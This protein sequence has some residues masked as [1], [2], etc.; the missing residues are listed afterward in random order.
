MP[1]AP[2]NVSRLTLQEGTEANMSSTQKAYLAAIFQTSI[3]GFSFLFIKIA[4]SFT[5][6]LDLLA[7][8]FSAA[9]LIAV[10]VMLIGKIKLNIGKRDLLLILP[11]A[12][13]YPILFFL[14]QTLGLVHIASSEAGIISAVSPVFTLLLASLFL[15]E[16]ANTPQKLFILL[17]V[18]GVIFIFIMQGARI[19]NY[20]FWGV[21]LLL[22]STLSVALYSILA[23]RL[24]IQYP[25]F[26]L[27]FIMTAFG[28]VI[29]SSLALVTHLMAGTLR[30]LFPP[31]PNLTLVLSV[32][33]LGGFSSFLSSFLSNYALSKLE[34][35]RMSIFGNLATV[36]TIVA[37]VI[38]LQE[39]F[40]WYHLLGTL[41]ILT[42]VLG[43]NFWQQK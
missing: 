1:N 33:Y 31:T 23:R 34:A 18:S 35:F 32:L 22:L 41:C 13:F 36:I 43:T 21:L 15:N 6:P 39:S 25:I 30:E 37:G 11:L 27:T 42:G 29:F 20:N 40:H 10:L 16:H 3:I 5:N 24:S 4:L 28:F 19:E 26:T 9:F 7:Y 2:C 12:L 17:S 8:R 38:F 14:F